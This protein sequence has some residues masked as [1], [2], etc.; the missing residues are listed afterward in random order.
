MKLL[1]TSG[2]ISN[3]SISKAFTELVGK[4]PSD[5]KVAY[6]PT[7][8][9]VEASNKDWVIKDFMNLWRYGY[10]KFDIVDPSSD[11]VDWQARLATA[12]VVQLSGG[13]TF[14][15]LDQARKTGLDKWLK[16]NI[17]SKVYVG[18]SASTILVTP[19]IAIAGFGEFHDENLANLEDLTGLSFVDFEVVPHS[20]SWASYES[21]EKYA[22]TVKNKVYALDD[23]SAI[24]VDG[25]KVEV[26]SEGAWKVYPELGR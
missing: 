6:I 21:V 13:N 12:D 26:I 18:G 16:E 11:G 10:S 24:K 14:H 3:R 7:A 1:L 8:S 23:M 2:G 25:D 17:E 4:S 5:T 15:L 19:S 20:P 9:N 22:T